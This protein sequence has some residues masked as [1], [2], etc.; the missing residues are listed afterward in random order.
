L[1]LVDT[2]GV[3]SPEVVTVMATAFD[4]VCQFLPKWVGG[5]DA[6]RRLVAWKIISLVDQGRQDPVLLSEL[7]LQELTR[8]KYVAPTAPIYPWMTA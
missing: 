7:T 2:K 4:R 1:Y 3:Y 6:V 5:K 8:A